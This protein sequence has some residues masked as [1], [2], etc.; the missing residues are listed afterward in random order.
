MLRMVICGVNAGSA[1]AKSG[2]NFTTGVSHVI[3]PSSTNVPIIIVVMVLVV[4]PIIMRVG[5]DG[6]TRG[7]VTHAKPFRMGKFAILH[8]HD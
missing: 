4:E 7:C 1:T 8:N 6:C 3:L 2:K 5:R